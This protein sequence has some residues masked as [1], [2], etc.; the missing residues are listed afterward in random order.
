MDILYCQELSLINGNLDLGGSTRE[1]TPPIACVLE[2]NATVAGGVAPPLLQPGIINWGSGTLRLNGN[3]TYPGLTTVNAGTLVV[4]HPNA[5]GAT[6]FGTVVNND[7][8]I[9][10]C[11]A[12]VGAEPLTLNSYRPGLPVF[13]AE[14]LGDGWTGPIELLRPAIIFS[15]VTLNLSGCISGSGSVTFQG[16]HITLDGAQANT[17]K[18]LTRVEGCLLYLGKAAYSDALPG[19]LHL[20]EKDGIPGQ[21]L[22]TQSHQIADTAALTLGENT[23]LHLFQ[24][25]DTVGT[26]N[27]SGGKV[28][29]TTGVLTLNGDVMAGSVSDYSSTLS[30]RLSLGALTRTFTVNAGPR[31]PD[32]DVPASV[33]CSLRTT[34]GLIKEGAGVMR[35]GGTNSYTGVTLVNA[36]TLVVGS[37]GAL[38]ETNASSV[39]NND[40]VLQLCNGA[41]VGAERLTPNGPG[42]SP[43]GALDSS[44]GGNSWAGL[45][46]LAVDTV[47]SVS[48]AKSALTLSGTIEGPGGLTKSLAGDLYFTGSTSNSYSGV[49]TVTGGWLVLNKTVSDAAVPGDLVIQDGAEVRAY[50]CEQI[51]DYAKVTINGSGVL[52][53]SNLVSRAEAIGSLSGSG[54]VVLENAML[55]VGGNNTGSKFTGLIRGN[56]TLTKEG[57][58]LLLLGSRTNSYSGATTVAGGILLVDAYQPWSDVTVSAQGILGGKGTVGDLTLSGGRLAPGSSPGLFTCSNVSFSSSS[59]FDVELNGTTAGSGYDQLRVRGTVGLGN[60]SLNVAVG[61]TPAVGNSFIIINN[62]GTDPVVGMFHGLTNGDTLRSGLVEMQIKY[63]GGSGNDVVLTVTKVDAPT[64]PVWLLP[65]T[66]DGTNLSL[67]WTGGAPAFIIERKIGLLTNESWQPVLT[68][69]TRS[70]TVLL[71]SNRSFYRVRGGN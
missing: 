57:T 54:T 41:Q 39:V 49:T 19:D 16:S 45:V 64:S 13:E 22:Y 46:T 17:Y 48:D 26:L 37:S 20:Y 14:T 27:L 69:P 10:V 50:N 30:G 60:S 66:Y 58:G 3:N 7:A 43:L 68:N 11:G 53:L 29:S 44:G 47:M 24:F 63:D 56:G 33:G 4:G 28:D 25:S 34:A 31:Q 55:S 35:L 5:L 51:N 65:P 12:V 36:G 23:L 6:T 21:V 70:V 38:G 18:G 9:R 2:I 61:F 52:H 8:L 42:R 15:A 71:D 40:A 1:F 67:S 59:K 62:D 32:L